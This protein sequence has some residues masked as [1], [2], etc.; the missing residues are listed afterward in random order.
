MPTTISAKELLELAQYDVLGMSKAHI[1]KTASDLRRKYG[2]IPIV[3]PRKGWR[4]DPRDAKAKLPLT[5]VIK[6]A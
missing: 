1:R 3:T 4:Y 6:A 2:I 5:R